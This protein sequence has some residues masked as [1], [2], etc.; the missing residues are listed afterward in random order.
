[1]LT[2]SK[3]IYNGISEYCDFADRLSEE[4]KKD[5]VVSIQDKEK[6]LFPL[7][8]ELRDIGDKLID[9]YVEHL[10]DR[11]NKLL[12]DNLKKTLKILLFKIDFC[13][14]KVYELYKNK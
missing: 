14:N 3:E 9:Q 1:M 12:V 4:V 8:D 10:K 2:D 13:K 6:I 11:G 7:I 5:D